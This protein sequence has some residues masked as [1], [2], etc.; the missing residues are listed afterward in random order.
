M[1][2]NDIKLSEIAKILGIIHDK[3]NKWYDFNHDDKNASLIIDDNKGMYNCLVCGDIGGKSIISLIIQFHNWSGNNAISKAFEWLKD[4]FPELEISNDWQIRFI[5]KNKKFRFIFVNENEL[6]LRDLTESDIENIKIMLGKKY[7]INTFKL[8]GL[9]INDG[10]LYSNKTKKYY[11]GYGIV[12]HKSKRI[13]NPNKLDIS[14]HVEG[15]TDFLTAVDLKLYEYGAIVFDFNK[16]LKRKLNEK[17]HIFLL[18]SDHTIDQLKKTITLTSELTQIKAIPL[19]F[20]DLSDWYNSKKKCSKED[21][22][23]L[24]DVQPIEEISRTDL[25]SEQIQKQS[26]NLTD[27]GNAERFESQFYDDARYAHD[28]KQW[29]IWNGKIWKIDETMN[30]YSFAKD[31]VRNIYKEASDEFDEKRRIYIAKH[32]TRSESRKSVDAM[33]EMTKGE[34][35]IAVTSNYFNNNKYLFNFQN[36]TFDFEYMEFREFKKDDRIT[37]MAGCLYDKNAEYPKW[38]DFLNLIFKCEDLDDQNELIQFVQIII[39]YSMTGLTDIDKLFF[40]YGA[41]DNGKT[42]FFEIIRNIFGDYFQKISTETL[43]KVRTQSKDPANSNIVDLRDKRIGLAS[44]LPEGMP[45]DET[46]VKMLVGGD[47][48]RGRKQYQHNIDFEPT[49]KFFMSGNHKPKIRGIDIGIWRRI[50]IIP[51][52]VQIPPDIK[53][54]RSEVIKELL[55]ESSGIIN[56]AIDGY[57]RYAE[58]DLYLPRPVEAASNSYRHESDFVNIFLNECTEEG[59][60]IKWK[61]LHD[62]Y[63]QFMNDNQEKKMGKQ[64]LKK[65]LIS[66]GYTFS[67]DTKNNNTDTC[68]GLNLLPEYII[69]DQKSN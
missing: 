43:I 17:L 28:I 36:G 37:F 45:L 63:S 54:E 3:G 1:K 67:N 31:T 4:H 49:H 42:T 46:M 41:G 14:I 24:I 5:S 68:F 22:I 10:K 39:G 2:I 29:F 47:L 32:A 27:M 25:E 66:R 20:K 6:S 65:E 51:F 60:K 8:L 55:E 23:S 44:E 9:N 40:A 33:L 62:T 18:D 58:K 15:L 53:R 64:K 48:M 57:Y 16:G 61:D 34:Q 52:T 21:I 50:C 30:I 35:R 13:Y 12:I 11:S 38:K 59:E 56:W 7:S 69:T 26:F 19:P